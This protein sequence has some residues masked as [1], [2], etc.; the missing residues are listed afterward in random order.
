MVSSY[1]HRKSKGKTFV[2]LAQG[3]SANLKNFEYLLTDDSDLIILSFD[4]PIKPNTIN[5]KAIF[6]P[7]STWAEGRN[8]LL[9]RALKAGNDYEYFIF[10][11]D[12]VEIV[13]GS[14]KVF[15]ELLL[16][17]KPMMGVPLCDQIKDSHRYHKNISAHHPKG[18]DQIVQ[19][20]H[21]DVVRDQIAIPYVTDL[22]ANSWW[23]ACEINQYLT[24][25]YY[26]GKCAQFNEFEIRNSVHSWSN[27]AESETSYRPGVTKLGL[28][29]CRTLILNRFGQQSF[30]VNSLFHPRYL[31]KERHAPK[32]NWIRNHQGSLSSIQIARNLFLVIQAIP[33]KLFYLT[34]R[35]KELIRYTEFN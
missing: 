26:R 28:E 6:K 2:Y 27:L 35:R 33:S 21:K 12:D 23:Y 22:D 31:P 7:N 17:Y 9:N 16:R 5:I 18:F 15:E 3:K 14:F 25:N 4:E 34:F 10:L 8:L 20:Y 30:L 19:A 24:L 29:H 1:R 32:L 11:D 13:L